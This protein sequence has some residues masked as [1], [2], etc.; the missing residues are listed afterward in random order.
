MHAEITHK[1]PQGKMVRLSLEYDTATLQE[2]TICGDFFVHP[3]ETIHA[4][5]EALVNLPVESVPARVKE[6]L[7][8]VVQKHHAE[9]IGIDTETLSK[10]ICE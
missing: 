4:M 5:E 7:D 8:R 3:E 2:A 9:L 6:L 1:I 10:L